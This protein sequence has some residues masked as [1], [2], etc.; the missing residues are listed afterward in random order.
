ML[1]WMR[2]L[3]EG[4]VDLVFPPVC[5]VC[6]AP[7]PCFLCDDCTAAMPRLQPPLC[8][9]CGQGM[10]MMAVSSDETF[11]GRVTCRRCRDAAPAFAACRAF[12][13]YDGPLR[14]AIAALKY[15]RL[16]TVA[17][18]LAAI[19]ARVL[20]EEP[21]L[22]PARIL[23]PVPLHP[24]RERW[25]GFNQSVLLARSL[26]ER[27]GLELRCDLLVKVRDAKPQVGL[28]AAQ[29]RENLREAFRVAATDLPRAPLLLVDDVT[30]TGS[31]FHECARTLR[32][33]GAASV[34]A[35]ALA[36]D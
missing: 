2:Q 17:P 16:Y 36:H 27:T 13:L 26:A 21:V 30:T 25:R 18:A 14:Q 32:E 19:L 8:S 23:V 34:Y 22:R 15:E 12:G 9:R 1:S 28:S 3:G 29:R 7:S 6:R 5:V 20:A 10:E 35:I 11:A 33:A 4:L 24:R 31:T